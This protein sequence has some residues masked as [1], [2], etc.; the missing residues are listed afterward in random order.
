[1]D[2]SL[3][4]KCPVFMEAG[5]ER[6]QIDGCVYKDENCWSSDG[7]D[8]FSHLPYAILFLKNITIFSK[9]HTCI[10]VFLSFFNP[11][12]CQ[13][14][15]T[16]ALSPPSA[17]F[18]FFFFFL[19]VL[20]SATVLLIYSWVGGCPLERGQP[21]TSLNCLCRDFHSSSVLLQ[22]CVSVHPLV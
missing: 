13:I 16:M 10:I 2:F 8:Y 7:Y 1:M 11:N 12:S 17:R 22:P 3:G 19:Y 6:P 14:Y 21:V 4:L 18:D 5:W 15:P 20:L 9:F